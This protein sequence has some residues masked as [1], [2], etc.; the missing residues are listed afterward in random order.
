M[1]PTLL[2]Q[3]VSTKVQNRLVSAL[4]RLTFDR[5]RSVSPQPVKGN[6]P[7]TPDP[8]IQA[9]LYAAVEWLC[10]AQDASASADGGVARDY[11]LR[12]G[13]NF[14]YPET[15]GYIA[16]TF[17]TLGRVTN[18]RTFIK[19]AKRMLDWLVS[20]QFASGAFQG[21]LVNAEPKTPVTFNTGQILIGL[22]AGCDEFG[23]EYLRPMLRAANWLVNTMDADGAWRKHPTPFASSG[24]KTY[25]T[26]VAWGLYE[27]AKVTKDVRFSDAANR[28]LLWAISHQRPNGWF[29]NC[30]LAEPSAPLTHTIGYALRGILEG[31]EFSLDDR[32]LKAARKTATALAAS[33]REDGYL[34][35]RFDS[36]WKPTVQ[37]SCLTGSVQI[38]CCFF[39]LHRITGEADYL[40]AA[41]RINRYVRSTML[42]DGA[43]SVVGAVA[44]SYPASGGYNENRYLSWA[45]KF[46]I[47]SNLLEL[48][49]TKRSFMPPQ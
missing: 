38:A 20:K 1:E 30:C 11:S 35:G 44:G 2:L 49:A 41:K 25:E 23:D 4:Q 14:S 36:D 10:L 37:W 28:N 18:N 22:A 43:R 46:F 26:H 48:Q 45:A 15:T 24:E 7:T 32:M 31:Y 12:G 29:P 17:I 5:D 34:A 3:L 6:H 33:V 13:W 40:D 39:M 42:M 16:P 21:G 19:R 9:A 47:D 27:A 8:G